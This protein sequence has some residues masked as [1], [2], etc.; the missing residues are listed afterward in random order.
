VSYKNSEVIVALV[1]EKQPLVFRLALRSDALNKADPFHVSAAVAA[2]SG[3]SSFHV[4]TD[5][6][7]IT[8]SQRRSVFGLCF[9]MLVI[10]CYFIADTWL[11]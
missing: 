1:F 3:N 10:S 6:S 8:K 11:V 4:T 5:T 2:Q 7:F 9:V